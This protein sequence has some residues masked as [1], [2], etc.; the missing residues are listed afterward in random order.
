MLAALVRP[1]VTPP[2]EPL[3]LRSWNGRHASVVS[4]DA[5][6]LMAQPSIL[7][8]LVTLA[9]EAEEGGT[10]H[11][12]PRLPQK[13]PQ[14]QLIGDSLHGLGVTIHSALHGLQDFLEPGL[15]RGTYWVSLPGVFG[16]IEEQWRVMV[17][18]EV[19]VT[20]THV[21]GE[22]SVGALRGELGREEEGFPD[23]RAIRRV[24]AYGVQVEVAVM[25]EELV[26]GALAFP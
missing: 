2:S 20:E 4:P 22:A 3:S 24:P 25:E 23:G 18:D 11:L 13:V 16:K 19:P 7:F 26:L 10:T 21:G 17:G 14:R 15:G 9:R 12:K 5:Q 1:I 6:Q 8:F